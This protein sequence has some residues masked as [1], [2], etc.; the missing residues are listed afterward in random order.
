VGF[1]S[2][3]PSTGSHTSLRVVAPRMAHVHSSP[4]TCEP[5]RTRISRVWPRAPAWC[6][7]TTRRA[8]VRRSAARIR[9]TH[10]AHSMTHIDAYAYDAMLGVHARPSIW[11]CRALEGVQGNGRALTRP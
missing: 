9:R 2:M 4:S 7:G 3:P 6:D 5:W 8:C 10:A 11:L 1:S